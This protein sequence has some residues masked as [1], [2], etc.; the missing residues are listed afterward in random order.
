M[1]VPLY[2]SVSILGIFS[3]VIEIAIFDSL[4][5][6]GFRLCGSTFGVRCGLAVT[7][8]IRIRAGW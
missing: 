5:V 3:F 8:F 2:G 4:C 1:S 6:F 7:V